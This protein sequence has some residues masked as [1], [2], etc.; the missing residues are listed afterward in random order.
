MASPRMASTNTL[1]MI[2]SSCGQILYGFLLRPDTLPRAYVHWY[3]YF[4]PSRC[5]TCNPQINHRIQEAGKIPKEC[6]SMNRDLVRDRVFKLSDINTLINRPVSFTPHLHPSHSHSHRP[7]GH[8]PIKPHRPPRPTSSRTRRPTILG[9]LLRSLLRRPPL[10][11][12]LPKRPIRTLLGSLQVDVPD[13][14]GIAFDTD[15]V[16]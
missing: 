4:T 2:H 10:A 16:V 6:V 7:P 8:N 13:L 9:P 12:L 14:R 1:L 11:Q 5:S 3:A 15:G